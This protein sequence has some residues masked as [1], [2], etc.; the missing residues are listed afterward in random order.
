MIE[1]RDGTMQAVSKRNRGLGGGRVLYNGSVRKGGC[2][3]R[4]GNERGGRN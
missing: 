3:R 4:E 1:A 2:A